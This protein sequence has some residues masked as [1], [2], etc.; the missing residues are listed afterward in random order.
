MEGFN[1][2]IKI[3]NLPFKIE[4]SLKIKNTELP[5][6]KVDNFEISF[7][8]YLINKELLNWL[9][10]SSNNNKVFNDVYAKV[11]TKPYPYK[12]K[13]KRL[14]KKWWDKHSKMEIFHNV[15]LDFSAYNLKEK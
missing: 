10:V 11:L 2:E 13:K 9:N 1:Y 6:P 15:E 4:D 14:V 7:E 5:S 3:E 12:S 8:D